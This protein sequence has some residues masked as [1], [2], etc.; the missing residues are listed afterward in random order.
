MEEKFNSALSFTQQGE[1]IKAVS[2]I[3]KD[4]YEKPPLAM[5]VPYGCQQNVSD[6]ERLKGILAEIGFEFTD[7]ADEA[8]LMLYKTCAVREHA[9]DRV[10]GNVGALKHY[11]RRKPE[12]II[13]I[14]GCMVQQEA[15]ADRFKK[16]YPYVDLLF[17]THVEYRLPEFLYRL[18]TKKGR[19][20]E[21]DDSEHEIVEGIPI[22]R[23]GTFK[24][25]L[26]IMHG[27][28]NFCTYC[29]VPYV[30]GREHS[31]NYTEILKEAKEMISAGFKDITLLGQNVNS[32]NSP[33][34]DFDGNAVNFPKL[35]RMINALE[36]DFR[37]RFMTSHPKD[38]S[39]ELLYTMSECS[40]VS[41]HLHLPF[42]SGN[43]RVL[44]AMNRR[45]TVEKYLSLIEL[46]RKLMPDISITS[47]II[48]G[49]PGETYEEFCDTLSL[50][51]KVKF[52]ALFTFI[53]S[54]RSGTPAAEMEDPV[55]RKEKGQWFRELLNLQE[56]VSKENDLKMANKTYRLL[57]SDYGREEGFMAGNTD[58]NICLEFPGD[59]S[60][61]GEFVTVE[62][63]MENNSLKAKIKEQ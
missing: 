34:K 41:K 63:Y 53:Y 58:G 12:L 28:N 54:K 2:E 23:D 25:W 47:D 32:Y 62:T 59:G 42:Q 43:D 49:F 10:F 7:N 22:R 51:K 13:G 37:I 8:D 35:L 15:V 56:K 27:C 1:Y 19:V 61:I 44:K 4:K 52:S 50:V 9:E 30:R 36:G 3:I 18:Y 46:A 39:D 60:L 29:I 16:S 21:I 38:C 48:V 57:V 14:C 5:V 17:G 31:R 6:S 20:F 24:G 40:K 45:Y 26:P 33:E 55:S 11:K